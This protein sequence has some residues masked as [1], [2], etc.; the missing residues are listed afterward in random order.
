[1]DQDADAP[2]DL[3][4]VGIGASAGGL[5]ALER[6]FKAAPAKSGL[7]YVVIQHLSPDFKS[8]MD[9]LLARHTKIPI[10]RV[11]DGMIVEPDHIYLLPPKKEMIISGGRLLLTDKD[12][13]RDLSLPID[14][15][16][17]SLA[18]DAGRCA[19]AIVLSGTGSDGS[20]GIR[21]VHEAGG[22]VLAQSEESCKFDGMP[23]S[24][25]DTGVVDQVLSPE[26]MPA[27]VVGHA[28][29]R[30]DAAPRLAKVDLHGIEL[31]FKLLRDEYGI[32]FSYYKPNTVARR[33]ER[34]QALSHTPDLES[35]VEN[36]RSDAAELNALYR[37]LLIGVT[38]FFR[39]REAFERLEKE[40]LPDLLARKQNDE[41]LRVWVA[42]CATGEE[43][44]SLAILI[45]EQLRLMGRT[46]NVKIFATDVHRASLE[47]AS[48]GIYSA[49][50]LGEVTPA[51]LERYFQ[52]QADGYHVTNELRQMVVFAVHNLIKDA[53]FTRLDLIT[54][55]NLLI[56][57]QPP[58]QKKVI[59]LFHFG[60]KTGG[61]L[62]LGPSESPGELSGEFDD[63]DQ[64]WK[65]YRKR[66]DIRLP[67]DMRL[68]LSA[69]PQPMR[70]VPATPMYGADA[71]LLSAYDRVLERHMPP[72][73][74]I[75]DRRQLVHTFG[76]AARFLNVR[77]GRSSSDLLDLMSDDLKLPLAGAFQRVIKDRE[78]VVYSGVRVRTPKGEERLKLTVEPV[79][80]RHGNLTHLLVLMEDEA[81]VAPQ[82]TEPTNI[83]VDEVSRDL[84]ASLESELH[85]TRENLQA[86]VEELETSNEEMQATNEEL[87]ASNEELQSTNE[88]L[89]SVNEELYT[90][91][92]EYQKKIAE[93]TELTDDMD[94]LLR[95]TD[96]GTIFLDRNLCI[97]K[98]TP[99]IA[100]AF[101][102]LPH[103]IG[104]RIDSFSHSIVHD[105]LLEDLASVLKTD[106]SIER[107]VKDRHG[108]SL[109]LRILPY[110][111]HSAL[112][113]VVL[114]LI[115]ISML[116]RTEEELRRT[117]DELQASNEE[118]RESII[119][120]KR[121][122]QEAREGVDLRDRFLAMLS[123]ELRNP[124]GAILNAAKLLDCE[125]LDDESRR[126]ANGAI[127]RQS[128]QMARLLDDLLD[129]SRITRNKIEI[130]KQVTD[131]RAA[132]R[133]AV[134]AVGSQIKA[135]EHCLYV[136]LP[137]LPVYVDGDPARL[138][139]IQ[140]NL[141]ANA[142]K[143]TPRGGDIW[144]SLT[145]D[146]DDAVLRV[147]DNGIGFTNGMQ[148]RM[149]DLFV[150]LDGT[151]HRSDGGMGVGLTLVRT[152][153]TLHNGTV[154]AS[155]S[156]PGKGAEFVVRL[157][158]AH[159]LPKSVV[160]TSPQE[161]LAGLRIL[162]IDDNADIR[163]TTTRLLKAFGCETYDASSGPQGIDAIGKHVPDVA[164]IDIG[165]PGMNGYE[166]ARHI[167]QLP[168]ADGITLIALTG[169]GQE[170]DRARAMDA[171]FHA[172]LVKPIDLDQLSKVLNQRVC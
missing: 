54:C 69:G 133:E 120:R 145:C 156:G 132:A 73:F 27:A 71:T 86:T 37:D 117:A 49:E 34:R 90:V 53:P 150:Q 96:I 106:T 141:L 19:I 40:I 85:Y 127:Q 17:R 84:M 55:R 56:Y 9:E 75:S 95:S 110:R 153:V 77:P 48:A 72:G 22:L 107:E 93:L 21:D 61:V 87:V 103:D 168:A 134:E 115:D 148:E 143:Y 52:R 6:F 163:V 39:D 167:R 161:A 80:N 28:T 42:G 125:G 81:E 131:L 104:R 111:S 154:T 12:P 140:V 172:H 23:R 36:L 14:H 116:K 82:Q 162:V 26:E 92:A 66:R 15:F 152:L 100:R 32:D 33:I 160:T 1:L 62:F 128:Q 41:E 58:V 43:A 63:L 139:Q 5:E 65:V 16:F 89:H 59:S 60:L 113:G 4:I 13:E 170:E 149:F 123:H 7:A 121:A 158:L 11:E 20:R 165:M 157:P 126:L 24:A 137:N 83:Q 91:N 25:I 35:Y 97:R 130:R 124:L 159:M 136:E 164:L 67:S 142:I 88:E 118:L 109:F 3:H 50:A 76:E 74:L 8:L 94:N 2:P 151:D 70:S 114:T 102:L 169:Y 147:R 31:I 29:N 122:E 18:Q 144:L 38:R 98:F 47:F 135:R 112:A 45:D 64:H 79:L 101:H 46:P 108:N 129:V 119:L 57:F 44:Y 171:G 146:E 99:Q 78:A 30:C 10:H 166:V 105:G 138:Q 155:S 68:P 51:R